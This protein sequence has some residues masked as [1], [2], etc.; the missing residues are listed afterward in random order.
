MA[1]VMNF[2]GI[3]ACFW[4]LKEVGLIKYSLTL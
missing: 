1:K 3:L 4:F 2:N